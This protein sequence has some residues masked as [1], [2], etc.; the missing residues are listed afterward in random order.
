MN[1]HPE[2]PDPTDHDP[3]CRVFCPLI[4]VAM[5]NP[6]PT[7]RTLSLSET[8]SERGI[9]GTTASTMSEDTDLEQG[10]CPQEPHARRWVGDVHVYIS[11]SF[12]EKVDGREFD[13]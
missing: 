4:V 2:Q 7:V 3:T 11:R 5:A 6:D 1:T 12:E 9:Y 13:S 8:E 10:F